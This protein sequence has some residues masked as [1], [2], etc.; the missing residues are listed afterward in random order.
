[1]THSGRI[2][3]FLSFIFISIVLCTEGSA[4]FSL[5]REIEY[6]RFRIFFSFAF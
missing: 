5:G 6:L 3:S 1:M 2:L 4:W